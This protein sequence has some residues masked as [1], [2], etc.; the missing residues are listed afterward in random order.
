MLL[1]CD[2]TSLSRAVDGSNV[3]GYFCHRAYHNFFWPV[4]SDQSYSG[5]PSINSGQISYSTNTNM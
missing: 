3:D 4:M 1:S 2:D 5:V